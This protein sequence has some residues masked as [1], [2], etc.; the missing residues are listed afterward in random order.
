MLSCS[1]VQGVEY[2]GKHSTNPNPFMNESS[3]MFI[4]SVV[5]LL[6]LLQSSSSFS[7]AKVRRRRRASI[8]RG[9]GR[10]KPA[11]LKLFLLSGLDR[12]IFERVGRRHSLVCFFVLPGRY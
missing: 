2:Y 4:V 10:L 3:R 6:R 8:L 11:F 5:V 1:K 7:D 12:Q 9:V